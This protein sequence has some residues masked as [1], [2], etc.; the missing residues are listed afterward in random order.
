MP[1]V[2]PQCAP[3]TP[4]KQHTSNASLDRKREVLQALYSQLWGCTESCPCAGGPHHA[5]TQLVAGAHPPVSCKR[6]QDEV[7]S[8]HATLSSVW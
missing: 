3:S 2:P 5:I 4:T 8:S 7:V 6:F 1:A